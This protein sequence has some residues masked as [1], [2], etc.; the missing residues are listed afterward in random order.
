MIVFEF[1]PIVGFLIIIILISLRIF[2]LKRKGITVRS[3]SAKRKKSQLFIYPVFLLILFCWL[4]EIIKP[5]FQISY[6]VLPETI[7]NLLFESLFLKIM[8]VS[9]ISISLILLAVTLFHFKNSLRFGLDENIRGQLISTG[10]FAISRNPFFLS[11]DLYFLGVAF[12]LPNLFF[13]GFA[14][15][16]LVSIHFFILKE[17]KFMKK[18]YGDEYEKYAKKV[19]RYF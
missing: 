14:L 13:I 6:S 8:G 4:F 2:L 10:I 15:L 9:L 7:T 17:E 19:Q 16:T 12:V 1:F 11:L 3:G 18:V 5:S